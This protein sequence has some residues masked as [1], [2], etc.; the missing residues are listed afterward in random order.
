MALYNP[1]TFLETGFGRTS[2][3][4][5]NIFLFFQLTNVIVEN[6]DMQNRKILLSCS[7]F[8]LFSVCATEMSHLDYE[9]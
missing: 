3:L 6:A 5:L 8:I 2:N 1:G 9:V 4:N 7:K